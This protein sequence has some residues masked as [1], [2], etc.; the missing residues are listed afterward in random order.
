MK[1]RRFIAMIGGRGQGLVSRAVLLAQES[2]KP[3][4]VMAPTASAA[5]EIMKQYAVEARS[6]RCRLPDCTWETFVFI[7]AQD[8]RCQDFIKAFA[9]AKDRGA[10]VIVAGHPPTKKSGEWIMKLADEGFTAE[11]AT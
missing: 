8:I 7:D 10:S 9:H 1:K 11:H 5:A 4:G 2:G 6:V 3:F